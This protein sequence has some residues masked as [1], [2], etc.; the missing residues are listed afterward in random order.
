MTAGDI[1][2][3]LIVDAFKRADSKT[4]EYL[5][6]EEH[7]H[8]LAEAVREAKAGVYDE[9]AHHFRASGETALEV[10]CQK[11]A[12]ELRKGATS[13]TGGKE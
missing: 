9:C 2:H 12:S 5:S 13:E 8:L 11:K 3:H 4:T 10:W 1:R 7:T 6:L